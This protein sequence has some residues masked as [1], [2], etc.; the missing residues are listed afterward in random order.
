MVFLVFGCRIQGVV[1][2]PLAPNSISTSRLQTDETTSN[3]GSLLTTEL[4]FEHMQWKQKCLVE[5]HHPNDPPDRVR[6]REANGRRAR[7]PCGGATRR[8][9][10][11]TSRNERTGTC[12]LLPRPARLASKRRIRRLQCRRSADPLAAPVAQYSW[13]RGTHICP[14]GTTTDCHWGL[15]TKI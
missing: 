15:V 1:G 6:R 2:L 12:R 13:S 8:P 10:R 5:V 9:S 7:P 14:P 11:R 3:F 4:R